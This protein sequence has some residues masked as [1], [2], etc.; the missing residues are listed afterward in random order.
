VTTTNTTATTTMANIDE[1]MMYKKS[2]AAPARKE[3]DR[4]A[5]LKILITQLQ[6]QDPTQPLQDKEFIAQ[7]AQFSALEQ[8]NKVA[9]ANEQLFTINAMTLGAQM[10]GNTVTYFDADGKEASGVVKSVKTVEGVV[11]LQIG[12]I[13]VDLANVETISKTL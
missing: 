7:M 12:E 4:D 1:S 8:M 11:K 2:T 6:Y 13:W 3:L 10:I 9:A 5:F